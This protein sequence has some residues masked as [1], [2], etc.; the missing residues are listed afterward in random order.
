MEIKVKSFPAIHLT[1]TCREHQ[2]P[3]E[4][5]VAESKRYGSSTATGAQII[6]MRCKE[7]GVPVLP[8]CTDSWEMS[9]LAGGEVTIS[10]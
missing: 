10:Q 9:I 8:D 5:N 1:S 6:S 7:G 3:V 2:C 4:I